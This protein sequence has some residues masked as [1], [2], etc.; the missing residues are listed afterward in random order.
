MSST[1]KVAFYVP[2]NIASPKRDKD[3]LSYVF[4]VNY[5]SAISGSQKRLKI[6]PRKSVLTSPEFLHFAKHLPILS[7]LKAV[8]DV[9]PVAA[10]DNLVVMTRTYTI[11]RRISLTRACVVLTSICTYIHI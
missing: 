8:D 2:A 5:N 4:K 6:F 9:S 1:N 3:I 11:K 10:P 7:S